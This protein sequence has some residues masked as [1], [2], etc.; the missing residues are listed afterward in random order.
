MLQGLTRLAIAAPR[1]I[2]AVAALLFLA[3]TIFG[4]PVINRLSGGGFQDPTS[5]SSRA[6]SVLRDKFSQTDQQML[7][8]VTAPAGVRSDQASRVGIDVANQLKRSPWVLS[9]SSAWTSPPPA[10]A[11][12]VSKDGKS[13]LIVA[14]L[15]GGENDAQTYA[16]KLTSQLVHDRDGVTMRAGGSAVAYFQINDQNERDLVLME[17]IAIPLSFAVLVWVLGGMVAAALPIVLG[18]LAIV[19]TMSVLRL[20]TFATDVSTYALDLSIAMGLALAID[21]NLLI[22]SRYRE[23]LA[24]ADHPEQALLRTMA[25]AGRTVVFSATTV[26]LSMAV[27]ALFPMYFLKSSAYTI[28]ATAVVVAVAA[29]VVTPAAIMLLGPRLDALDAH[30]LIRRW[31]PRAQVLDHAHKPVHQQFWYQSTRLVLRHALP[32]GTAVVA[33]MLLLGVPFLGVKWGFP[34]ERVLPKSASARQVADILDN[35]F[36]NGLGT[37]I[38]VVVPDARGINPADLHR[39]AAEL[40]RVP[41]VSSVS[42]PD[43]TYVGGSVAAPPVAATGVAHGS[44]FLTVA[45]TA[46]LYSQASNNQLDRLHMVA[47]PAGRSVEMTGF[48]QIN[49]DSVDAITKQ[50]PLVLVMIAG[51]TF[52][53]LFLLTGS[54]VLPL[55]ALVCNV[56]S[57]TAAFGAMA[58]IFQDGH[59]GAFGTTPNG[60]LNATIPV[61]LFCIAFGLAMD[62]EVFLVSRIHEYWCASEP[63]REILPGAAVARAANDESVAQGIAGIGRV[64]TT[65]AL[66]MSISFAALIPAHVSFMRMLGLGLTLAVLADATLVRMALVPA[67]IH[68]LGRWTWWAPKTL[69][70]LRA[71]MATGEAAATEVGERRWD[72][73]TTNFNQHHVIRRA[74]SGTEETLRQTTAS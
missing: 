48:A 20:I 31:R 7:I 10:A 39:Y 53:L 33:L 73:D 60:T 16:S 54:A 9:V 8:L 36:A 15:K 19:C 74:P 23:E 67:F 17:S 46:P 43:G 34:D 32:I 55:Q 22:I 70:R 26:G 69:T 27:M 24:R 14:G 29:V 18:A 42:A 25:T 2:I 65:A 3:A 1:R 52:S 58:W 51:I 21:Y 6:A 57:L 11:A 28:V 41:D 13:G 64:V 49:R 72:A 68:L 37:D 40:S 71:R 63:T 62:Y 56:L 35:D 66:V 5:E 50:L 59:L 45:T 47:T 30:Q 61:L 38:S 44:A 4:V 12:M